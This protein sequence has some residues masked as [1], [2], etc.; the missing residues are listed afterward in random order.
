MVVGWPAMTAAQKQEPPKISDLIEAMFDSSY[1]N[2]ARLPRTLSESSLD[3]VLP[4]PLQHKRRVLFL[5]AVSSYFYQLNC[6]CVNHLF[7]LQILIATSFAQIVVCCL[8]AALSGDGF[9]LPFIFPNSLIHLGHL[10]VQR[11]EEWRCG[12]KCHIVP[13]LWNLFN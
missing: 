1:D 10:V 7:H 6:K 3:S 2:Q 5:L 12:E 9:I 11:S 8:Y 13:N 4:P